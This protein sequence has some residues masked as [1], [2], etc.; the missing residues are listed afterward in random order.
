MQPYIIAMSP[1]PDEEVKVVLQGPGLDP[2]GRSYVF[3]TQAS[4]R[5]E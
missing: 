5:F 4:Y 2:A 1:R 3:A